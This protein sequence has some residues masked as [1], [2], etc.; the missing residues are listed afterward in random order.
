MLGE[1]FDHPT[2]SVAAIFRPFRSLAPYIQFVGRI[3]RVIVQNDP[4]HPDNYGHIVTHIGMNLD[5]Q[6]KR[7]K[8]FENDDQK[9]WEEVTGGKEPEPP[10][11]VAD[12]EA[13]M[14]LHEDIVVNKEIVDHLFEEEFTTAEDA[15]VERDLAKKLEALGLDPA[16][17]RQTIQQSRKR[18]PTLTPA[19]QPF[20][21]LPAKQWEEARK[22]LS[23]PPEPLFSSS[24]SS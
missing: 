5:E 18:G 22:R 1:G 2:L 7:F 12:G 11:D 19:A 3:L 10:R 16:L 4:S 24:P 23:L 8:Q 9:F 15:D 21:V 14:K 17:A 6:L 20:S 13:R